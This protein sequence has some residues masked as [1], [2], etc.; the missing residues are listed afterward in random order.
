MA[1]PRGRR[2]RRRRR[3]TCSSAGRGSSCPARRPARPTSSASSRARAGLRRP[4]GRDGR[5]RPHDARR[6]RRSATSRSSSPSALVEAVVGPA[7]GRPRAGLAGGGRAR[8]R[9]LARHDPARPRRPGDGCRDRGH[10]RAGDRARGSATCAPSSTTG[11]PRS[12]GPAAR[13][14]RRS[15]R[16]SRPARDRLERPTGWMSSS[17]RAARGAARRRRLVRAADGRPRRLRGARRAR[18]AASSRAPRW[19]STRRY[20]QV[21][22]YLVLRD[23]ERLLPDAPDA[24]R[25][26]RAAPRPVLDRRRRPPQPGRRRPAR[27]ARAASGAR[28]SSPTSSPTFR[29]V[30]LLND[31]TTEVGAVHLGAVYVAD[32][33]GRPVAIRETDKLRAGSR[34]STT[35]A[36]VVDR[37]ET[38]SRLVFEA[39]AGRSPTTYAVTIR[40]AAQPIIATPGTQAGDTVPPDPR[41]GPM[42][43]KILVVDDDPNVQRLL[44]Y[45]LKQEGY[46]VVVAADGA[47]GF[48]L[49]GAEAPDLIL[50][51]VMLP[52]LDGYQVATKIRTEE[53]DAGPRPDHHA[54]RRARGRAEGPRPAGRRRRLPH[55]AVPPGR[56]AGPDQ[57]PARPVRAQATSL[58]ARPPLGRILAFYGAKGGVGTT[59]IAI[60]AAIALHR[61]LGRKVVPRRR[62]PPVRRPPRLPRPRARPQEHRRRRDRA[63]D[64]R[65][66]SSS[67]SWSST[68][69]GSTCCSRRRRRRPP[70]S[71]ARST[72]R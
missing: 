48:R 66:T 45:T 1:G 63:V 7:G 2:L 5:G 18:R 13:T 4:A 59:T 62:Q 60:N 51:D 67:R 41:G 37:L 46:E 40:P 34:R 23:G 58:L 30:A 52:K 3:P 44:Q 25:R 15:P 29:L 27:R 49:W 20:K 10:E 21:I 70:S 38:W 55:Q 9:R 64:R 47:E 22:P 17:R 24:G 28:S 42:A 11:S 8:G 6:R 72:C 31:D 68:T 33:A 43:A 69:R 12:S 56:A 61:E 65:A 39:D 54:H 35:V 53:G 32:A 36:A 50:L 19:R 14:R 16:G 71:S 26:R 57:E